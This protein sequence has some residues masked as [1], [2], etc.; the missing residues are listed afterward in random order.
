M[1]NTRERLGLPVELTGTGA[2]SI[3]FHIHA[4]QQVYK[5]IAKWGVVMTIESDVTTVGVT[6]PCEQNRKISR[7][8]RVGIPQI[9]SQ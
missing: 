8:M 9:A 1:S 3:G 2:K 4:V 5:Q 6:A 7:I